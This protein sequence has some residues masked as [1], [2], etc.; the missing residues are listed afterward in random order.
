[1]QVQKHF[2]QQFILSFQGEKETWED[3]KKNIRKN[4]SDA[5]KNLDEKKKKG[6][7]KEKLEIIKQQKTKE[8]CNASCTKKCFKDFDLNARV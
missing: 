1:M 3:G 4:K 2:L 5:D 7:S 8:G 6:K